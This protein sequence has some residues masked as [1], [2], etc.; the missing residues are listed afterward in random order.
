[1]LVKGNFLII[2]SGPSG[3]GK[4]SITSKLLSSSKNLDFSVSY[5]TREKRINEH[6]SNDYIYV[7]R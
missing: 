7:S 4:S 1:M 3:A 5:T 2:I 6:E